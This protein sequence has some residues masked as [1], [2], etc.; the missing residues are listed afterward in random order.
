MTTIPIRMLFRRISDLSFNKSSIYLV[1]VNGNESRVS[2]KI[3]DA[4]EILESANET[5]V[6]EQD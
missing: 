1:S 6:L 4:Q 2:E 3:S 5:V